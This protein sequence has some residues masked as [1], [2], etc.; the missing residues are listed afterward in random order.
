MSTPVSPNS[1]SYT[2]LL[3]QVRSHEVALAELN[4]LSSSRA[5]YQKN[6]SIFFRTTIQK[7]MTFEQTQLDTA[8]AR[9]QKLGS[10]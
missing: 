3:K 2:N 5:V 8:K 7:A 1:S 4:N 10:S 6:G 9:L